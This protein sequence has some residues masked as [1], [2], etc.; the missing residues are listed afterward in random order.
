MPSCIRNLR[1][2]DTRR[3]EVR[4]LPDVTSSSPPS[5]ADTGVTI[6]HIIHYAACPRARLVI[7]TQHCNGLLI[8]GRHRVV[9]N[10]QDYCWHIIYIML[11]MYSLQLRTWYV[12]ENYASM[13]RCS[14]NSELINIPE[15]FIFRSITF[16]YR[17]WN[18]DQA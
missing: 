10:R 9:N 16:T 7:V 4:C 17:E 14:F 1:H 12:K 2:V 6:V 8:S 13:T 15:G 3:W 5:S 11:I 18:C